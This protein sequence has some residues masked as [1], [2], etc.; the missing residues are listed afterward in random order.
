MK[1]KSSEKT[2]ET[3]KLSCQSFEKE[4]EAYFNNFNEKCVKDYERS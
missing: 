4:K 1:L 3:K 2:S